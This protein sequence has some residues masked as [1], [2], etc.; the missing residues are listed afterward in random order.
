MAST[1]VEAAF[2]RAAQ[3]GVQV[4]LLCIE[5]THNNAGGTLVPA[6]D[7]QRLVALGRAHGAGYVDGA[8]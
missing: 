1:D 7:M 4:G 5:N 8:S 6:E 2:Q 3:D